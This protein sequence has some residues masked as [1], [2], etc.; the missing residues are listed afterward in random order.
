MGPRSR[1]WRKSFPF[2]VD[3]R[4]IIAAARRKALLLHCEGMEVQEIIG[5]LTDPGV[6]EGEDD[7]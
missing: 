1:R 2:Y 5:T 3:G 4:G 7:V 6:P